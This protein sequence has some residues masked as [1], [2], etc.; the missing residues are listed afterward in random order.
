MKMSSALS[1]RHKCTDDFKKLRHVQQRNL[2][3]W[4]SGVTI[5]IN[6][7]KFSNI[8]DIFPPKICCSPLR[9][10]EA[11]QMWNL[12]FFFYL[13]V[14]CIGINRHFY[15]Y[16]RSLFWQHKEKYFRQKFV[17]VTTNTKLFLSFRFQDFQAPLSANT[18]RIW[19]RKLSPKI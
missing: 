10:R 5:A 14:C 8:K 3:L 16:F 15:D 4:D 6:E 18:G 12:C 17:N 9:A 7:L 11:E 2:L 13:L 19:R 1:I